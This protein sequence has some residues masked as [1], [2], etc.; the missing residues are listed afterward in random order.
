M[1]KNLQEIHIFI[2][3]ES[4][5]STKRSFKQ[6]RLIYELSG[7]IEDGIFLPPCIFNC[8]K[9]GASFVCAKHGCEVSKKNLFLLRAFVT[10]K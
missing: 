8:V 4:E 10:A 1:N 2:L 3:T 5:K 9:K 7:E 6:A